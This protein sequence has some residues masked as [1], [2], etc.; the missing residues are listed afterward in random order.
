MCMCVCV[1]TVRKNAY[2][3]NQVR[4]R[5]SIRWGS[6]QKKQRKKANESV[7]YRLLDLKDGDDRRP[8]EK[9]RS[10]CAPSQTKGGIICSKVA[11]FQPKMMT[12]KNT[13]LNATFSSTF[14]SLPLFGKFGTKWGWNS[15]NAFYVHCHIVH[16]GGGGGDG[17][18][19]IFLPPSYRRMRKCWSVKN[20]NDHTPGWC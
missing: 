16:G 18:G 17:S 19:A 14:C 5:C 20:W 7:N 6:S 9:E 2:T 1:S 13:K 10:L 3:Y 4:Y 15:N 12:V 8:R 11:K